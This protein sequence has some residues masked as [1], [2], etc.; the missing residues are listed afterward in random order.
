M[1]VQHRVLYYL[2][3]QAFMGVLEHI[4]HKYLD[5]VTLEGDPD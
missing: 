5:P 2:C 1:N 3:F 4:S